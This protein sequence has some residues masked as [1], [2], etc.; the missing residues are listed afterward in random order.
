MLSSYRE[1]V[2][3]EIKNNERK[4]FRELLIDEFGDSFFYFIKLIDKLDISLEEIMLHQKQKLQRQSKDIELSKY[5]YERNGM[6]IF[7]K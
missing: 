5:N 2:K 6:K 3:E 1:R 4:E 7:Q